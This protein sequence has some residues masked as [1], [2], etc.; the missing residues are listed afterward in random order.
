MQCD[1]EMRALGGLEDVDFG[2]ERGHPPDIIRARVN[3]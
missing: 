1:G 3:S 2:H